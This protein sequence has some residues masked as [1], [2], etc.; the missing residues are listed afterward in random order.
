MKAIKDE[1]SE[2]IW[3]G[4]PD[5]N[6]K[7]VTRAKLNETNVLLIK[8]AAKNKCHYIDSLILTKFPSSSKEGIHYPPN[9]SAE[10]GEKVSIQLLKIIEKPN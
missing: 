7:S 3:I 2:C 4:P 8:L 10:W 5:A 1:N 6:S 9:L